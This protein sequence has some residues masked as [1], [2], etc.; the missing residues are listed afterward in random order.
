MNPLV[1]QLLGAILRWLFTFAGAW[2]VEHGILT[3]DEMPQLVTGLALLTISLGWS[4]WQKHRSKRELFTLAAMRA[5][6]TLQDAKDSIKQ[7]CA[8]SPMTGLDES[9]TLKGGS[10]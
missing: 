1:Q 5:G 8:A 3:A 4:L 10:R 7:G 2:M 9:P 6:S